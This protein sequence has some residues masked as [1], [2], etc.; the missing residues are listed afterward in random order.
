M[1]P[2]KSSVKLFLLNNCDKKKVMNGQFWGMNVRKDST[3]ISNFS[4]FR[5]EIC[6]QLY[7][8]LYEN[9]LSFSF[10]CNVYHCGTII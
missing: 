5:I 6:Y 2:A 7:I 4:I 9:L 3:D 8:Y 10:F 1:I